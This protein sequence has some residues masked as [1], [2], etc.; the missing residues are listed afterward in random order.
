[1]SEFPKESFEPEIEDFAGD[2]NPEDYIDKRGDCPQRVV[3][4]PR[5]ERQA[6]A[7]IEGLSGASGSQ[8]FHD[9][10]AEIKYEIPEEQKQTGI[11]IDN[12][13]KREQMLRNNLEQFPIEDYSKILY[14]LPIR[15]DVL[16]NIHKDIMNVNISMNSVNSYPEQSSLDI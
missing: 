3:L 1:M 12:A 15:E 16:E 7:V 5:S 13:Y 8:D 9:R 6:S 2:L 14:R 11:E 10:K 4:E